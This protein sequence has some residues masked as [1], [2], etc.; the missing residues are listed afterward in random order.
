MK[1]MVFTMFADM[2]EKEFG[3][4]TWDKL[5]DET[6]P[7]SQGIYTSVEVYPDQELLAYVSILSQQSEVPVNNLVFAFGKYLMGRFQEIH[8]DFF[9]DHDL[10]SF[11]KS[12]HDV[13]HVEVKK[14]HPGVVLPEFKYDD[15]GADTLTMFYHSPRQLCSLAE[16]L[17][18]GAADCFNTMVDV[19]HD[20]CMHRGADH[21]QLDL[22]FHRMD[23]ANAA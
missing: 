5:I 6:A 14:L 16:G 9:V 15:T 2:I 12:V 13:I 11:L 1:G 8:S 3:I 4:D 10:K 23:S 19:S 22:R 17:I 18:S 7:E 20:V 21:C